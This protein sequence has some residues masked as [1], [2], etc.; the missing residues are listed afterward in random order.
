[1]CKNM[2]PKWK[3]VL[4]GACKSIELI[5]Q[6]ITTKYAILNIVLLK[7][8]MMLVIKLLNKLD[9]IMNPTLRERIDKSIVGKLI[10]AKVHFVIRSSCKRKIKNLLMSLQRNFKNL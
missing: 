6:R 7:L 9:G 10:K 4:N 5:M 8:D 1:M 2:S 3:I